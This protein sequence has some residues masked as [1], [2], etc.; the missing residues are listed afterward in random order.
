MRNDPFDS[1]TEAGRGT[2]AMRSLQ[3]AWPGR[4]QAARMNARKMCFTVVFGVAGLKAP[5]CDVV[6]DRGFPCRLFV[7][8]NADVGECDL[9]RTDGFRIKFLD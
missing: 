3:E 8:A 9:S 1:V 2:T 4:A 5:V 7:V 6:P